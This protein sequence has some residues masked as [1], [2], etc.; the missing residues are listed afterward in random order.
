MELRAPDQSLKTLCC[1]ANLDEQS[2][3]TFA[4]PEVFDFFSLQAPVMDYDVTTLHGNKTFC[5]GKVY[6]GFTIKGVTEN[7]TYRLPRVYSADLIPVTKNEVATPEIVRQHPHIAHLAGNFVKLNESAQVLLLIGRDGGNI[8]RTE[9]HGNTFPFAHH[10]ALGWAVVGS[11]CPDFKH[12]HNFC[13]LHTSLGHDHFKVIPSFNNSGGQYTLL[14]PS[15]TDVFIER[16]DDE[17]PGL[18][19]EDQK[20]LHIIGNGIHINEHGNLEMPLP[21]KKEDPILPSNQA[22]VY[23]RTKGTLTRLKSDSNK[24]AECTKAMRKTLD[25]GYIEP[26]PENS[27]KPVDGKVWWI[28]VFSCCPPTKAQG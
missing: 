8:L 12:N 22:A 6:D 24:L 10:T 28:P 20:F 7:Y 16:P 4:A 9:V 17:L 23:R 19:R 25:A 27:L 21:F 1:Y 5:Q 11:V 15:M 3:T 26:V 13:T 18:S 2:T 14:E